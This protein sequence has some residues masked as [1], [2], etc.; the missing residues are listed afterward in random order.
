MLRQ[1]IPNSDQKRDKASFLLEVIEYIQ[2]LQEKADKY[3]TSYQGWNHEPAKLLNWSN[4]NQQLVPEGV[5]FAPKL[6][7]EKNNIP[8]S[9]L[10]TA[11]GVVIDHPT[12]ATTSPFPLSIQSNSFFS[13]VIA[14]NPVPQFHARVASSEAVEPSP[15]S[16]SQKEEEDEEVLEGNI[17]ISSV[18]SQGL[19]KTLREALEN[20]GVD[21]TKA[22]ISVEIELAK[23][24]SSSSF[25]V[26]F[27]LLTFDSIQT[28]FHELDLD[29][30]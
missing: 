21:L 9:V 22:S 1:L 2:F 17:R 18:Y 28:H 15:S 7:E 12:T 5:A 23:Q 14:G 27:S 4:N 13:P 10:A 25:K 6:E 19:V 20:S 26:S 11:Q 24:S 29:S 30:L 8:V 3:V 16:R